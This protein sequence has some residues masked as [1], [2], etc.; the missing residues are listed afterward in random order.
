[1]IWQD[2][3]HKVPDSKS[4]GGGRV[5][6]TK[7]GAGIL[8]IIRTDLNAYGEGFLPK[9]TDERVNLLAKSLALTAYYAFYTLV[10][11]LALRSKIRP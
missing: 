9:P 5:L 8:I 4:V 10:I 11:V 1:M 7:T 6:S 3:A 2:A